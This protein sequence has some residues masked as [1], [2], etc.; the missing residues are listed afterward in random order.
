MLIP[1]Y[2][3]SVC[4]MIF[5]PPLLAALLRRRLSAPWALFAIGMATFT[6]SQVVHLPLNDWL[7]DLGW[8]RQPESRSDAGLLQTALI[9]GLT[10][11]LCEELTR[12]LGYWLMGRWHSGPLAQ[13]RTAGGG[14]M[15]GLGHG[16]IEAMVFGGVQVAATIS[17]LLLLAPADLEAL[18]AAQSFALQLQL[19]A[20]SGQPW[21]AFMPLIERLLAM[22]IHIVFSL[23]VL[24]A[25][26]RRNPAWL[27]LAVVYHAFLDAVLV[28]VAYR[29]ELNPWLLEG[30][31]VLLGLPG[32]LWLLRSPLRSLTASNLITAPVRSEWNA[33]LA[34]LSKELLQQVRTR[35]L[36]VVL[37]VFGLFGLTSPLLAYFTPQMLTMIPGAEAFASLVPTPN[38]GDAMLQYQK[39]LT[40]FG[41]ILALLLGMSAV[42]GEKEHGT[43]ALVL[44]KPL[45]RWAFLLSKFLAQTL[46]YLAGFVVAGLGC[47]L[48][49]WVLFGPLDPLRFVQMNFALLAW[50]LPYMALALLGSVLGGSI[51]AAAGLGML[52]L[53]GLMGLSSLP[54]ISGIMPGALSAWAGQL[55]VL[56]AGIASGA[57]GATTA[58]SELPAGGPLASA[59]VVVVVC[60][61][62]SL[63]VFEQQEL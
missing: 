33:F 35:R 1:L 15:L 52:G 62:V 29:F 17:A 11:G 4:L 41:F 7:T 27:L 58:S 60:Y 9:L 57:P 5:L 42:A 51:G 55:G 31:V 63:A 48:Y 53:V 14:L 54:L 23:M 38:A 34:A 36:L 49:T 50:L 24:Q 47:Y 20:L 39:N 25:F 44:S 6:L 18:P 2:V 13:A 26:T 22:A 21:L 40:Q 3:V 32:V 43:A 61:I 19:E 12:A 30:L 56:A 8:L 16:G 46:V 28:Y 37:A 59:L 10:A 45:P